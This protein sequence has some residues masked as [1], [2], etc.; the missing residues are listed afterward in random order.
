[1]AEMAQANRWRFWWRAAIV[2]LPDPVAL[3]DILLPFRRRHGPSPTSST[4]R[5]ALQRLG[6]AR[7]WATTNA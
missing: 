7:T 3:N 5:G 2:C 1:M 6:L 4:R